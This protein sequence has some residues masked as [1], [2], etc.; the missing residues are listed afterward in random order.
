MFRCDASVWPGI[1]N[2][3]T[4]DKF[5]A[6]EAT[7]TGSY[8][9]YKNSGNHFNECGILEHHQSVWKLGFGACS[10]TF[11]YICQG[12]NDIRIYVLNRTQIIN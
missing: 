6:T 4:D 7:Y 2:D 12:T 8:I 1:Y 9:T 5:K 10:L 11:N 3:G